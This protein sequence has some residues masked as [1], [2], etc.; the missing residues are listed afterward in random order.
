MVLKKQYKLVDLKILDNLGNMK[1][2]YPGNE[3]ESENLDS[4]YDEDKR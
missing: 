2:K 1:K 4:S 3:E